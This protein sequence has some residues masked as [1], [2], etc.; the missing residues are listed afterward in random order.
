MDLKVLIYSKNFDTELTG[1]LLHI[2]DSSTLLEDLIDLIGEMAEE[3][4]DP[5]ESCDFPDHCG[6]VENLRAE[7]DELEEELGALKSEIKE[8]V[9]ELQEIVA[10]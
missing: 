4:K 1:K 9:E 5:P 6:H 8:K 10:E 3:L 2:S 7:N